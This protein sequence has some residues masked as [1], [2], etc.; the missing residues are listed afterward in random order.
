MLALICK[1]TLLCTQF[2]SPSSEALV[3][4]IVMHCVCCVM[5]MQDELKELKLFVAS[6]ID[7]GNRLLAL[8]LVPRDESGAPINPKTAGVMQLYSVVRTFAQYGKPN[9]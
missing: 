8:D 9:F 4:F 1:G 6:K 7:Y 2:D 3:L 5:P